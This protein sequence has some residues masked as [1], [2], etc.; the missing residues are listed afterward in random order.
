LTDKV[1]KSLEFEKAMFMRQNDMIDAINAAND[2]LLTDIEEQEAIM[3]SVEIGRH[4]LIEKLCQKR[5]FSFISKNKLDK[6]LS[7]YRHKKHG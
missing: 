5:V 7:V 3:H 4:R 2:R 1:V 6:N